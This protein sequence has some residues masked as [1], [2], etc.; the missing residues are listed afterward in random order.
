MFASPKE[1]NLENK[2][3]SKDGKEYN[4]A[5]HQSKIFNTDLET[6]DE[7]D[8]PENFRK[9]VIGLCAMHR[10]A[11]SK[12]MKAIMAKMLQ[13]YGKW[14][15]FIIFP[16]EVILNETVEKWPL[17]DCLISFH[18]MDFPLSKAMEYE[19]LRRP[20]V[21]NDLHRQFDLL[22]RRKVFRC[23]ERARIDHP[24]YGVVIRDENGI[25]EA[26]LEEYNDHIV[27]NG[28][29]F[30]KP[31]VEKPVSAE[32]HNVYIYYP[33]SVGG[34][35]QR[36]FR[37]IN[38][39][40][41]RYHTRSTVRRTGSYIYEEFIPADG[42][43]VK[44]YAVGPYYAHAEARK[45][46]GLDGKVERDADGKEVR[47]PVIL[48]AREKVMARQ[49]VLA[50]GQTVC[51]FDLLRA[52]GK[53]YVCDVNGFSFVKTSTKYYEDTARILG[54]T[55][56]KR[57]TARLN[58]K[59]TMPQQEEDPPIVATPSG[60]LMELRC[61]L[62]VIR[63]GDRTPKQ[64]MKMLVS[65]L[66]FFDL[67]KKHD[68]LRKKEIKMKKPNQLSEVLDLTKIIWTEEKKHCEDIRNEIELANNTN[69]SSDKIKDL[70]RQLEKCE[71][72]VKKYDQMRTVLEMYGHFSGINRKVQMKYV[73]PKASSVK[74]S[75]SEDPLSVDRS[76]PT[77]LLILKW[78]GE[79]TTAGVLQAEAL[80]KLFRTLYPGI[81]RTDGKDCPEDTQGLGFLR[82]HSTYRHDLKIYAS[83]EGRVQSTAAAFAKGLLALEGE[84]T[85]IMMQMVK[86]SNTD[87]LLNDDF[88]AR[89]FQN[90]LKAYLHSILQVNRD[91]TQDDYEKL[92]P[93]NLRSI[94]HAMEFI[95]NPFKMCVEISGYVERMCNI[96]KANKFK[97]PT[98]SL[99]L[100]ESWN[101]A[102][103]RWGKELTE[104]RKINKDGGIEF[105]IS[106]IPDI[107]DNIK[108]D[109]EH[110][111]DLCV[112]NEG[113]FE[114]MYLCVKNMADI[115]VPQEYGISEESKIKI[116]QRICSPLAAKLRNDLIRCTE[117]IDD[118]E[119][120]TRL[121]PRASEGIAT[122]MRHVRTRLYF[123]SESHIHTLMNLI[124]YGG[125]MPAD[126]K[127]WQ[128][129]M[130]F[131]SGVT[132]FNYMT[133][134][135]MMVYED[136]R[137]DS[138]KSDK[139]R[140]HIELLFS[141]GLYPC[142]QTEKERIYEK[143]M[144][145]KG[146]K[147]QSF[148]K[149]EGRNSE[150]YDYASDGGGSDLSKKKSCTTP[151]PFIDDDDYQDSNKYDDKD[152]M[153]SSINNT[154]LSSVKTSKT[155]LS[156]KTDEKIDDH[157]HDDGLEVNSVNL[158]VL[159]EIDSKPYNN[160]EIPKLA[161]TT[162]TPRR[163]SRN[164][165]SESI[166]LDDDN[167]EYNNEDVF[168]DNDSA[169]DEESQDTLGTSK[170][171][172]IELYDLN[173]SK[174]MKSMSDKGCDLSAHIKK[175]VFGIK[176]GFNSLDCND[177]ENSESLPTINFEDSQSTV[178]SG[179][180][181]WV[182][183]LLADT[184]KALEGLQ[185][186]GS[187]GTIT[188]EKKEEC[189]DSISIAD[190]LDIIKNKDSNS[191]GASEDDN[192]SQSSRRGRFP[193]KFKHHTV[194][195]FAGSKCVDNRLIS[196]A[197][198]QGK[199]NGLSKENPSNNP[200]VLSTAVIARSNSAPRLQTFKESESIKMQD[201]R[202]FWPPLRSLETLHDNVA[203]RQMKDFLDRIINN[204]TPPMTPSLKNNL[205]N[206]GDNSFMEYKD[207]KN[208][209]SLESLFVN[210]YQDEL[211]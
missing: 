146:K 93:N 120:Q 205:Q 69:C 15:E 112:N 195:L 172:V 125:F 14:I 87:G 151:I 102:E 25:S 22:D 95:K 61:V 99:Y 26:K 180:G 177:E 157:D 181:K 48:S 76:Q 64:K 106:K 119:T 166:N 49:V 204:I 118:E 41:S 114:R 163:L 38:D 63:H 175:E 136:S 122:P 78:G 192:L 37:K 55:I 45:C 144:N 116:G 44:V 50:F 68:G 84:L 164:E 2:K 187:T 57:L 6:E 85:P 128:R 150:S 197:V 4:R 62:A 107:Y 148:N 138:D 198:L 167:K 71:S 134:I 191:N 32:D 153:T 159:S 28:Q 97:N 73:K 86:S 158:V 53:S 33:S 206:I 168:E 36:L 155:N 18:S 67:F 189:K 82:L 19:K 96:I 110:N 207:I 75:D 54:N 1:E 115:V 74:I 40:S 104:F 186:N 179:R 121:D 117:S 42:T 123:T 52:N 113:E 130:N 79:L 5:S 194:N 200:A 3:H 173:R 100:N 147:Q 126:D 58:M 176:C 90:E 8:P 7:E 94:N 202:R 16:E 30:N 188:E 171:S 178:G 12:P 11:N 21:I 170:K 108:Y 140:F 47:Y 162:R 10:K 193:Y 199:L 145:A 72:L 143:R 165:K 142:F 133:Q 196:N 43:D 89:E 154:T 27:I 160:D 39:R 152:S 132:E 209:M 88:N 111:P 184:R 98:K 83:D 77:L 29:V 137:S 210:D 183:E 13:Y 35:S 203:Y 156:E 190:G 208:K 60:K 34:G 17:C 109:M 139:D 59:W 92:N 70:E 182:K 80:G 9:I 23:L 185:K 51:G 81:R 127:K 20:Y 149:K 211:K 141:P 91:F 65:D 24:R 124:R 101:L 131:L 46:P 169:D 56:L 135:V 103:R 161:K 31:F 105:D 66:R 174:I 201:I 129:A